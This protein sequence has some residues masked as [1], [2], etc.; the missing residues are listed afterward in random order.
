MIISGTTLFNT[1]FVNDVQPIVSTNLVANY[2]PATGIS[3]STFNDS[4][5]NGYNA[6]IYN[7][8]TTATVNGKTVLQLNGTNQYYYYTSGYTSLTGSVTFDA[9][10]N[11]SQASQQAIVSEY[12]QSGLAGGWEDAV[13]GLNATKLAGG[14]YNG[15]TGGY[16]QSTNTFSTNTWYNLVVTY[17]S[18]VI[19]LYVNGV[20]QGTLSTTR[21]TT[22]SPLYYAVGYPDGSGTYLGNGGNAYFKGYIGAVKFYNAALNQTQITQNFTA[23]RGR[24]GI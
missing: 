11:T 20:S 17:A 23:L 19:T 4:S 24:Y 2:D 9:W 6:T 8:P 12:G 1:G 14:V 21:S 5:G 10:F 3:G 18:S 22:P 16:V 13:L 15:S 7:S